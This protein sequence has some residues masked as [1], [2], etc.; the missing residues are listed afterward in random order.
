MKIRTELSDRESKMEMTPMI[1]V[2]FLLLIFFMCTLQFKTLEGKLSAFLPKDAGLS[3]N[4]EIPIEEVRVLMSTPAEAAESQ[5]LTYRVGPSSFPSLAAVQARLEH[6]HAADEA[7]PLT[8]EPSGP[9]PYG[10]VVRLLDHVL[11]AGFS[12]VRF[13]GFAD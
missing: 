2:T 3:V 9:V 13:A 5:V 11:L 10:E 6:L 12:D 8:L 7:R 4:P 1:D